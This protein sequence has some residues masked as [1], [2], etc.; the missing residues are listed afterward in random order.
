MTISGED[1]KM[2]EIGKTWKD[3]ALL[4]HIAD[5]EACDFVGSES[6]DISPAIDDAARARLEIAHGG[7]VVVVLPAPL[8]PRRQ[9]TSPSRAEKET[10]RNVSLS[11]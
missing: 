5:T 7:Q 3:P 2:F 10:Q 11:P 6:R 1:C 8:R 4:G 9:T